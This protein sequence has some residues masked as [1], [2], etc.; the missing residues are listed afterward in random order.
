MRNQ[1]VQKG[2]NHGKKRISA[3]NIQT[4]GGIIINFLCFVLWRMTNI[5]R[6]IKGAPPNMAVKS[7]VRSDI[8]W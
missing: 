3:Q 4:T 2:F 7:N 1:Y 6:Y 8:R 5:V